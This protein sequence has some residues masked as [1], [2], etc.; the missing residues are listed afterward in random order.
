MNRKSLR[1]A[2]EV[3]LKVTNLR[4]QNEVVPGLEETTKSVNV[5]RKSS[6]ALASDQSSGHSREE[7]FNSTTTG[8]TSDEGSKVLFQSNL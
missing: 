6:E 8:A 7:F 2:A 3:A 1:T 5:S 4:P